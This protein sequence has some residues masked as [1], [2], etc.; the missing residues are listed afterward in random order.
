MCMF[1][2]TI[3]A[4]L[5]SMTTPVVP[6]P[7]ALRSGLALESQLGRWWPATPAIG[8]GVTSFTVRI[9]FLMA[10]MRIRA[11]RITHAGSM[12]RADFTIRAE[13]RIRGVLLILAASPIRGE[14]P[15]REG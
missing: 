5:W 13:S 7:P 8:T 11:R 15:I 9:Q 1:P 3:R 4:L 12:I 10:L 2:L 14:L 6:R